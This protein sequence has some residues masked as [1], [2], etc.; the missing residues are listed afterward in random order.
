MMDVTEMGENL[1]A[2]I[3]GEARPM[4]TPAAFV[5]RSCTRRR[6]DLVR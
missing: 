3:G 6:A 1:V 2:V 5:F 4:L